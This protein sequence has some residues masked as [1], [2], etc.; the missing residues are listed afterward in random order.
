MTDHTLDVL[1]P[2]ELHPY[3]ILRWL[4]LAAAVTPAAISIWLLICFTQLRPGGY[5]QPGEW[6]GI[7]GLILMVFLAAHSAIAIAY[8]VC[9]AGVWYRK[10]WSFIAVAVLSAAQ[11]VVQGH[12]LLRAGHLGADEILY[13]AYTIVLAT[14]AVFAVLTLLASASTSD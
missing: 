10:R 13:L 6:D 4:A 11:C 12:Y 5:G 14:C 2:G 9:A 3:P 8:A 7:K 1:P